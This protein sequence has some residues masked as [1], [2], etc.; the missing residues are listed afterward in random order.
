MPMNSSLAFI[1]APPSVPPA[2]DRRREASGTLLPD[3]QGRRLFGRLLLRPGFMPH[4]PSVRCDDTSD[5]QR[6]ASGRFSGQTG[7]RRLFVA[8]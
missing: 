2:R 6:E 7:E 1:T 8:C 5:R 3:K 4:Y